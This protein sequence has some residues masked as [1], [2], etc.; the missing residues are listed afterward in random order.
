MLLAVIPLV[1]ILPILLYI[2]LV[3]G[4]QA[5][6][7]SPARHAPAIVLAMLPNIAAWAQTQIDGALGAAGSSADKLGLAK[8]GAVGVV[9]H[10]MALLGG[11]AVLA[12]L[13]WAPSPSSL[14]TGN[15]IAPR[16]SRVP[17]PCC[18]ISG[19]FTARHSASA[20]RRRSRSAI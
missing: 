4:A 17:A 18:R 7:T 12:G 13:F 2:G 15:S 10:G 19:L 8:L 11:G 5:F 6:Q 20:A 9:Y 3:I 16:C 1:T 14:L